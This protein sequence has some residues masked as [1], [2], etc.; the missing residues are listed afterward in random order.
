MG[1]TANLGIVYPDPSGVPSRLNW[2]EN[3]IKSVDAQVAAYVTA[4]LNNLMR[5][6]SSTVTANASGI[7][8][9]NHPLGRTPNF[10]VA[11]LPTATYRAAVTARAGSTITVH[12]V[13]AT[14]GANYA[15]SITVMWLVA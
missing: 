7:A 6:G 1:T 5:S 8:T 3:P 13:N 11:S 12:V 14:T 9:I 10:A 4:Q 2:V 15:G